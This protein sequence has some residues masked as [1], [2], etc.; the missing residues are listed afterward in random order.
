MNDAVNQI[1]DRLFEKTADT[2]ELCALREELENHCREHYDDLIGEGMSEQEALQ[3]LEDGLKGM[4]ELIGQASLPTV[5]AQQNNKAEQQNPVMHL[6]EKNTVPG[7]G[8]FSETAAEEPPLS[9]WEF[10]AGEIRSII[11]QTDCAPLELIP[12]PGDRVR[13]TCEPAC[14][15]ECYAY[16]NE[17]HILYDHKKARTRKKQ[18]RQLSQEGG[19]ATFMDVVQTFL[20]NLSGSITSQLG[21]DAPTICIYFPS[22]PE[23]SVSASTISGDI[24]VKGS[25]TASDLHLHSTGSDIRAE[26]SLCANSVRADTVGGDIRAEGTVQ[27]R[28]IQLKSIS[29]DIRA[30]IR[31]DEA[32]VSSTSG[33]L[34]VQADADHITLHTVSGDLELTG[35]AKRIKSG[36]TSGDLSLLLTDVPEITEARSVSGDL[37]LRLGEI[38]PKVHVISSTVS[39]DVNIRFPDAGTDAAAQVNV[40]TVSGDIRV[41]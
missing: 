9:E 29:G 21:Q 1:V 41:E 35:C 4:E 7:K 22:D 12:T 23:R 24:T 40:S 31:A 34:A 11:A 8:S 25:L 33:D 5:S 37:L 2:E 39:G 13:V 14:F 18:Q 36:T 6:N 30:H 15:M 3:V 10:G 17:L 32:S 27:A 19:H 20:S 28:K 38:E 16:Q 26:G